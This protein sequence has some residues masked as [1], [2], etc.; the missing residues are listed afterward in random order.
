MTITPVILTKNEKLNIEK[1]IKKLNWDKKIFIFDS[2][3]NDKTVSIA[4]KYKNIE[5]IFCKKNISYIQK[6]NKIIKHFPYSWILILD[7][8]YE[9]DKI[10]SKFLKFFKPNSY[11]S[12]YFF[13][14]KN[15]IDDKILDN[16]FYPSK[17]LLVKTNLVKLSQDG[18]KEKFLITG[19]C[20][21]LNLNIY[22]NDRKEYSTWIKNQ[23][24]YAGQEATKIL[25]VPFT[26]KDLKY[27]IRTIPF[28]MNFS[29]ILYHLI[30]K[31]ILKYKLPGIKY[32]FQRQI[33][34]FLISI[35]LIYKFNKIIKNF[36]KI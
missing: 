11:F 35:I 32:L 13:K 2:F 10:T 12:A 22:H 30:Y 20:K 1:C 25:K 31:N 21:Y 26:K 36:L 29:L 15:I 28:L 18:H 24:Y 33:Y 19:N 27:K 4:K 3:S 17:P 8:D 34:E 7:A 9:L 14:I 23:F 16:D 6:I 5:V